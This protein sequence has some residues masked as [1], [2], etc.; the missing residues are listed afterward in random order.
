MT[1]APAFYYKYKA[2]EA[3]QREYMWINFLLC[4]L[5][6]NDTIIIQKVELNYPNRERENP[7][8]NFTNLPEETLVTTVNKAFDTFNIDSTYSDFADVCWALAANCELM[9]KYTPECLT[10][11]V[12]KQNVKYLRDIL[13]TAS[14][15]FLDCDDYSRNM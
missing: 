13:S 7:M 3:A 11:D 12:E 10:D 2:C 6:Y 1:T 4:P 15:M 5:L 9:L 8:N 14:Q